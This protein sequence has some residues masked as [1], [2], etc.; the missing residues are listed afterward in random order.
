[1]ITYRLSEFEHGNAVERLFWVIQG[2]F[3]D[4]SYAYST[5]SQSCVTNC[6]LYVVLAASRSKLIKPKVEVKTSQ[7]ALHKLVFT[8]ANKTTARHKEVI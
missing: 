7:K 1:M 6:A 3:I 5:C 4:H 8:V 2:S